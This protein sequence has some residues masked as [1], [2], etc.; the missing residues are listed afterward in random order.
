MNLASFFYKKSFITQL[1]LD[2][3]QILKN[4]EHLRITSVAI[5]I[6]FLKQIPIFFMTFFIKIRFFYNKI[7]SN[8]CF[9]CSSFKKNNLRWDNIIICIEYPSK[10]A[11]MLTNIQDLILNLGHTLWKTKVN[12]WKPFIKRTIYV[13]LFPKSFSLKLQSF[14]CLKIN[15]IL[16]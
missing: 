7:N 10:I 16:K 11:N 15:P 14:S 1:L 6:I 12:T 5:I 4:L 3:N 13:R 8:L 2:T 9:I